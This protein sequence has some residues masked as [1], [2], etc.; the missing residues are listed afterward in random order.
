MSNLFH[1][2]QLLSSQ[3]LIFS[4]QQHRHLLPHYHLVLL[5]PLLFQLPLLWALLHLKVCHLL[6]LL[7]FLLLL[8]Y[9]Y[10]CLKSSLL[11]HPFLMLLQMYQQRLLACLFLFPLHLLIHLS[12]VCDVRTYLL[13]LLQPLIC[14]KIQL[15][16]RPFLP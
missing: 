1:F 15:E 5:C 12:Q 2:Y 11:Q 6:S 3:I 9:F 4:N 13:S 10:L 8:H 16:S 14:L 7:F